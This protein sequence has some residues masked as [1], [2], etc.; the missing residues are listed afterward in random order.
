MF[1]TITYPAGLYKGIGG[2]KYARVKPLFFFSLFTTL[3]CASIYR[4]NPVMVYFIGTIGAIS[5][6]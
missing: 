5:P 1:F 3:F 4:D 6:M 2:L